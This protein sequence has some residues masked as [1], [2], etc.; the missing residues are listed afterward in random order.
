M[1]RKGHFLA[2]SMIIIITASCSNK[3]YYNLFSSGKSYVKKG[4]LLHLN[5]LYSAK[6]LLDSDGYP[7]IAS[8]NDG[9]FI[10]LTHKCQIENGRI[11]NLDKNVII[12]SLMEEEVEAYFKYAKKLYDNI[13]PT[14]GKEVAYGLP[15]KI[16]YRKTQSSIDET[17]IKMEFNQDLLG[18]FEY[19]NEKHNTNLKFGYILMEF[20]WDWMEEH[21]NYKNLKISGNK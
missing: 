19:M 1:K 18:S 11:I 12:M 5:D 10:F 2:L 8:D 3:S 14:L 13:N 21:T 16:I 20:D 7:L 17:D 9:G 4:Y 15:V 6:R